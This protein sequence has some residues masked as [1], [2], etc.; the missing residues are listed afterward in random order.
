MSTIEADLR[1]FNFFIYS[2]PA[3]FWIRQ[4]TGNKAKNIRVY[5]SKLISNGTA[6][7]LGQV[8]LTNG[9]SQN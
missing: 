6:V 7:Y 8:L 2:L 4:S 3:G 1:I 5:G 9:S